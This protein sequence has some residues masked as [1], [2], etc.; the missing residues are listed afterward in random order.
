MIEDIIPFYP[1]TRKILVKSSGCYLYDSE[2]V[3]YLDLESG[4]WCANLGHSHPRIVVVM[5]KQ[6]GESVHHGYKFRNIQAENLSRELQELAGLSGGAG[7]FLSSGSEAVNL[8]ITLARELTG[9]KRILK[10]DNSY[11]SAFGF[12]QISDSNSCLVSI[13]FND[14]G[15]LE[16]NEFRD[17]A[18]V[19]LETGGASIDVVRF[20]A[21]GFINRMVDLAR[22]NHCMVI[23]DEVTTGFGRMGTWFGFQQY[24]LSPDMVVCGKALGN[25]YP[26]SALIVSQ[27]VR[28]EFELHPFIYAQSH[29]NDPFGCAVGLEVIRIIRDEN[30]LE[31]C[32]KTGRYFQQGL[33]ELQTMFPQKVAE[34]RAMGLMLAMEFS[35]SF[36]GDRLSGK[37]FDLGFVAGYKKNTLRFLPPLILKSDEVDQ[38]VSALSLLLKDQNLRPDD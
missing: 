1:S 14:I 30:L 6:M 29:Q 36:D 26:V 11:L 27:E 3:K 38:L 28:K 17:I 33:M 19:L 35:K 20:P 16:K 2:G 21:P 7:V 24:G 18:A 15:A 4:V 34:V 22:Q 31:N 32:Q 10:I 12:G 8:S 5:T 25:G 37:L 23:S 9:R 13:P